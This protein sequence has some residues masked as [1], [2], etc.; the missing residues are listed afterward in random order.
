[1]KRHIDG[2]RHVFDCFDRIV[3]A[4]GGVRDALT[5]GDWAGLSRHITLEWEARKKLA[6]GVTTPMI[7]T[8][9]AERLRRRR[10]RRESLRRRRRWLSVLPGRSEGRARCSAGA[11][12]GRRACTGLPYRNRRSS[13]SVLV[14]LV[15][16]R[17][18]AV[19]HG[20]SGHRAHLF[21]DRR[22]ARNQER[23]PVQDSRVPERVRDD[24]PRHRQARVPQRRAAARHSRHRQ[25]SRVEDPRDCRDRR[26]ALSPGSARAVSADDSRSAPPPGRRPEDGRAALYRAR[27]QDH[28]GARGCVRRRPRARAEGTGPEEGTAHSSGVRRAETAHGPPLAARCRRGRGAARSTICARNARRWS[29][30]TSAASAA[31]P[32]RRATSTSSRRAPTRT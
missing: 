5:R 4:A 26:G 18:V 28:R 9:I 20:K 17:V 13:G 25:G 15:A 3:E 31:A 16:F 30:T 22:S 1:M 6:P 7:E 14:A 32:T 24:R 11:D 23:E 12:V 19:R 29:S 21:G 27:H 8:L 10:A 2:D